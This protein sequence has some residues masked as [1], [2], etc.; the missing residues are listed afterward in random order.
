MPS[1]K[2]KMTQADSPSEQ[3]VK[4]AN[5]VVVLTDPA[6][7]KIAVKKPNV[8]AQYRLIETVGGETANNAVYMSMAMPVYWVVAIDDEPVRQPTSRISLEALI[9]QLDD[10]GIQTVI[11]HMVE[12]GDTEDEETV[13]A[14]LKN[15]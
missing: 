11:S 12:T 13:G 14:D 10:D 2:L 15:D 7:R 6:G 4:A 9:Q 5:E 8:L 1:A 3:I